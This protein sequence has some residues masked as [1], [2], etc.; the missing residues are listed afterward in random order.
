[1]SRKDRIVELTNRLESYRAKWIKAR[2]AS[3]EKQWEHCLEL[4]GV[5]R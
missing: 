1:V 3:H 4:L 5:K 2:D